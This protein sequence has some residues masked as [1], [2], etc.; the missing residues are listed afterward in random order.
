MQKKVLPREKAL[1]IIL[2][3]SEEDRTWLW[4]ELTAR[5]IEPFASLR[6]LPQAIETRII[7]GVALYPHSLIV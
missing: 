6:R 1:R 3:I 7:L 5:N 4:R 2:K